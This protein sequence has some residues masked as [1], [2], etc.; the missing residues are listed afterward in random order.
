MTSVQCLTR[1]S[2]MCCSVEVS[3]LSQMSV[4]ITGVITGEQCQ[5]GNPWFAI[6]SIKI[7]RTNVLFTQLS[8]EE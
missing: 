1:L 4:K 6:F 3:W 5:R 2:H 8:F 7:T